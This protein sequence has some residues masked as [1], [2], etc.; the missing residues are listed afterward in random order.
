MHSLRLSSREEKQELGTGYWG[1]RRGRDEAIYHHRHRHFL[2][3]QPFARR[4]AD[5]RTRT[6][7]RRV[8]RPPLGQRAR[9]HRD[10]RTR[11]HALEREP[12]TPKPENR[13]N[14]DDSV[15]SNLHRFRFRSAPPSVRHP[16][17][18]DGPDPREDRLRGN[19]RVS[20]H[21]PAG[22]LVQQGKPPPGIRRAPHGLLAGI[23]RLHGR[24]GR[25]RCIS[26]TS[27]PG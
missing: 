24:S 15:P 11:L 18:A 13:S 8:G 21:E 5:D 19:G 22:E 12:L 16:G 10:G 1:I 9:R 2:T 14:Q 26:R 25:T 6:G 23:R 27:R 20:F 7:C 3:D 4:Q 17:L